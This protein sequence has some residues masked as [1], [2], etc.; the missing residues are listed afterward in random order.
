[1]DSGYPN[2][3]GYL[4]PYRNQRY[5][6]P[7]FQQARARGKL[8]YF[9][10]L[11]SSLRNVVE[12]S[13]GVLKMKWRILGGIPSYSPEKQKMIISACMCLHNFIRDSAL[14]DEHFDMFENADYFQDNGPAPMGVNA[15][16]VDDG[17]MGNTRDNIAD[18]LWETQQQ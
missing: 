1:V 5:H 8:E 12:R 7:E 9:N 4:A 14:Q 3:V 10:Y 16:P 2:R 18:A 13:F 17:T 11:H 6:V 15:A